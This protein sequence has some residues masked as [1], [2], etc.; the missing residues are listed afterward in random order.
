MHR[1]NRGAPMRRGLLAAAG[2]VAIVTVGAGAAAAAPGDAFTISGQLDRLL[3]PGGVPGALDLSLTNP[4]STEL[5]V[6]EIS[7]SVASIGTPTPQPCLIADFVVTQLDAARQFTLPAN[8]TRTLTQLGVAVA[9]LPTVAMTNTPVNQDGCKNA[10]INLVYNGRAAEVGGVVL[11][12]PTPTPTPVPTPSHHED[13]VVG[14]VHLP[15][16][17]GDTSTFWIG[18]AGLGLIT[19]GGAS[20]AVARRKKGAQQ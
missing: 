16:T 5:T 9:D 7:V 8:S 2:A 14:G 10:T 15:G 3:Y 18:L 20:V 19:F 12:P 17:G 11:P 1:N 13:G 6:G 4:G